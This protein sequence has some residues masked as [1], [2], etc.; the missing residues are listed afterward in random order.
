MGLYSGSR[1]L[2]TQEVL[3]S[4]ED[5]LAVFFNDAAVAE[6]DAI[7]APGEDLVDRA[8]HGLLIL[9]FYLVE[10]LHAETVLAVDHT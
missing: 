7:E 8:V 4:F 3:S 9:D 1:A 2:R 6:G 10:P 5:L